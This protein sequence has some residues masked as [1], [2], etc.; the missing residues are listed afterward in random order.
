M[1]SERREP[2]VELEKSLPPE[3]TELKNRYV[4]DAGVGILEISKFLIGKYH[5]KTITG[6][7]DELYVYKD[8]I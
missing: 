3:Y 4:G 8:G 5:F 7:I 6:K 1:E 2:I